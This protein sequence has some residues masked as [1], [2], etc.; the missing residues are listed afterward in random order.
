MT[1]LD[2]GVPMTFAGSEEPYAY[3]EVKSIGALTPAAM[4]DQFCDM[5]K[6]SLGIP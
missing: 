5:I 4:S 1:L 2:F 6:S 3:V